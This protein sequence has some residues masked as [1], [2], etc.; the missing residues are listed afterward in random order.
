MKVLKYVV[1]L[2]VMIF[3]VLPLL[4]KKPVNLSKHSWEECG[5][6]VTLSNIT[7]P[8]LDTDPHKDDAI[9]FFEF[10][11]S[12]RKIKNLEK[13]LGLVLTP[14]A[15]GHI[16]TAEV[17]EGSVP[18]L[19]AHTRHLGMPLTVE[20]DFQI[21]SLGLP[22]DP[23]LENQWNFE[24]IKVPDAWH[25]S[26][27]KGV[28]VAVVDSGIA[29][30]NDDSGKFPPVKDL[31]ETKRVK[32]FDYV[33]GKD[34]SIDLNGHG[35][36]VAGTIAQSTNNGY[37]TAG[38]AYNSTLMSVRV[39]DGSGSG[40]LVNVADGILFAAHNGANIVNLSLGGSQPSKVLETAIEISSQ[41]GVVIV[42]AAGNDG[43]DSKLY[44]AAYDNVIS[45]A[46]TQSDKHPAPYSQ[47]G[48][49]ID[50]AAPGGNTQTD[51]NN[52]GIPD[53]IVQ[54]TIERGIPEKHHFGNYM[55][56]SMAS[57]HVAG[58]AALVMSLGI[59][60]PEV[61]ES[62]LKETADI[63]ML[64]DKEDLTTALTYPEKEFQQRYGAGIVQADQAVKRA[65]YYSYKYQMFA[66]VLLCLLV[67]LSIQGNRILETNFVNTLLF[68]FTATHV[69][70]GKP[71]LK[72]F[73][74]DNYVG[75]ISTYLTTPLP[76]WDWLIL[77]TTQNPLFVTPLIPLVVTIAF[78]H[79]VRLRCIAAGVSVGFA[80]YAV[81]EAILMTSDLAWIPGGMIGS[82]AFYVVM[83]VMNTYLAYYTLKRSKW[84]E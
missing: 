71:F 67:L 79:N 41:K 57:P 64:E 39:L 50:I 51:L 10:K 46:A 30:E 69:A 82:R 3:C 23:M 9:F 34:L 4:P 19:E 25:Y 61:V 13:E 38:I 73:H 14:K 58:V 65:L 84:G 21:K 35:T 72:F 24:Q 66:A 28:V 63:S 53:G 37:G 56:T 6:P 74:N 76:K 83:A 27:G 62:I 15:S 29:L 20:E 43:D 59:T 11:P 75:N 8:E 17:P 54:E 2:A 44:P 47:W 77:G 40:T 52:D 7:D 78:Y 12:K 16:Y 80:A 49:T 32:G 1:A 36:H 31:E 26:T 55:G 22:D 45:V 18:Q 5:H 48:N 81:S 60:R 33:E 42:A 68:S 70:A